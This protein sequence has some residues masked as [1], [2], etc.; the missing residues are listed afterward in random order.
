M[1]TRDISE[2]ITAAKNISREGRVPELI[3][4]IALAA[5]RRAEDV[6]RIAIGGTAGSV[7][8]ATYA[9]SILYEIFN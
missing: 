6:E 1:A 3:T 5:L 8:P 2:R 4:K 9:I 7:A